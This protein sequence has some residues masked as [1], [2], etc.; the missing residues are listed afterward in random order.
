MAQYMASAQACSIY[1]AISKGNSPSSLLSKL[2][3]AVVI[4]IDRCLRDL[5]SNE[6][7]HELLPR[8]LNNS[9]KFIK[10]FYL[11]LCRYYQAEDFYVNNETGKSIACLK[12]SLKFL[13]IHKTGDSLPE[14][15]GSLSGVKEGVDILKRK[16]GQRLKQIDD[17]NQIVQLQSIANITSIDFPQSVVV[18]PLQEYIR[19][20]LSE[21]NIAINFDKNEPKIKPNDNNIITSIFNSF[22]LGGKTNKPNNNT[23]DNKSTKPDA[24]SERQRSDSDVARELQD[25]FNKGLE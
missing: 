13:E 2:C 22:N 15:V 7:K 17:E 10:F 5:S 24:E 21:D 1:K 8:D 11:S 14:L 18:L 16:V 20:C 19:P 25:K 4:D 3:V 12:D 23:D 9:L 6:Y